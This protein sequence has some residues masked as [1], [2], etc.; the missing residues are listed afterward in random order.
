MVRK[1]ACDA[2]EVSSRNSIGRKN[3][4]RNED[5]VEQLTL[6]DLPDIKKSAKQSTKRLN[7]KSL[8]KP[9][10]SSNSVKSQEYKE[11]LAGKVQNSS[12]R[13]DRQSRLCKLF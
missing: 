3:N 12:L 11:R 10:E 6:D 2:A 4:V 5:Y 9:H 13:R 7:K 1:E 8:H